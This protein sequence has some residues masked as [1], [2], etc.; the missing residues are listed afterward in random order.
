MS[1]FCSVRK[2]SKLSV[3]KVRLSDVPCKPYRVLRKHP[4]GGDPWGHGMSWGL[5]S[6][7]VLTH[8]PMT[9]MTQ[10][11]IST[12]IVTKIQTILDKSQ[13]TSSSPEKKG[14]HRS[15]SQKIAA[16]VK[17]VNTY[18]NPLVFL[19]RKKRF[20]KKKRRI[21]HGP[22]IFGKS[23]GFWCTG[24]TAAELP[25]RP[26]AGASWG[27]GRHHL[28]LKGQPRRSNQTAGPDTSCCLKPHVCW[29]PILILFCSCFQIFNTLVMN[30]N[31]IS[32]IYI[33]WPVF[34]IVEKVVLNV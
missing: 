6:R 30:Q 18:E 2:S 31:R 5:Q 13:S 29:F 15:H 11:A 34:M 3:A 4:P 20:Q 9:P 1:I 12:M 19:V 17:E 14:K 22:L 21:S 16:E 8:V 33:Y 28:Q 25:P 24:T 10:Y 32:A 26:C 7:G 27:P 23:Y